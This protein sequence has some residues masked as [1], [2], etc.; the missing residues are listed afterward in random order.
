MLYWI[1]DGPWLSWKSGRGSPGARC[2]TT[3]AWYSSNCWPRFGNRISTALIPKPPHST[4]F[5][6]VCH[7]SPASGSVVE[8]EGAAGLA[9]LPIV[10]LEM[11][12][13]VAHLEGMGAHDFTEVVAE[14]NGLPDVP[15]RAAGRESIHLGIAWSSC[16]SAAAQAAGSE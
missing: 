16:I 4:H 9:E 1:G 6:S 3:S 13:F 15:C 10:V 7:A 8:L 2:C 11:K 12:D 14:G 5:S